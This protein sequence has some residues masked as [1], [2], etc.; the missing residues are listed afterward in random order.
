MRLLQCKTEKSEA[1][2]KPFPPLGQNQLKTKITYLIFVIPY[3]R[4]SF[5]STILYS[6]SSFTSHKVDFSVNLPVLQ[7]DWCQTLCQL[8]PG[9]LQFT[10]SQ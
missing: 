9:E 5:P 3:E 1:K 8:L 6:S 4:P 7:A 2:I 10:P